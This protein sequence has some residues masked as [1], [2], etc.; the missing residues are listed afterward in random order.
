MKRGALGIV[1]IALCMSQAF[2]SGSASDFTLEI[3]GNANMDDTIDELDIE[4]VR[5]IIDGTNEVTELADANYNG[6]IDE[7]DITQIE[8]IIDEEAKEITLLQYV[9]YGNDLTGKAV[10]VNLPI[11]RIVVLN[12][13]AAEG[14]R[15]VGAVDKIVGVTDFAEEDREFWSDMLDMSVVGSDDYESIITLNP[16]VVINYAS[17]N[18]KPELEETL[19][20]A[21]ITVV[22]LDFFKPEFLIRDIRT[23]GILLGKKERSE[24]FI[25]FLQGYINIIQERVERIE[26]EEKKRIFFETSL[27][28]VYP[29]IGTGAEG[30]AWNT[31]IVMAGGINIFANAAVPYPK[32][33][34]EDVLVENPEIVIRQMRDRGYSITNPSDMI[35]MRDEI[36]TRPGWDEID[37]IKSSDVYIIT[38]GIAWCGIRKHVGV[39]YLAKWFYPELFTDL[40]PEEFHKIWL[41][42]FEGIEYKGIWVYPKENT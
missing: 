28:S 12:E 7:E 1:V 24:G 26:P 39:I 38:N 11:E 23:L 14:I 5:G 15:I 29:E 42:E 25:D 8:L 41:E 10:T 36:M 9:G 2:M 35:A 27:T 6:E 21:G 20:P 17:F 22:R 40:D 16:Q 30:S 3:F 34:P 13:G 31:Q 37:A 19:E 33:S 18:Y 32:V 4:Y